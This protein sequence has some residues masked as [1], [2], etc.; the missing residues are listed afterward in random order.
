MTVENKYEIKVNIKSNDAFRIVP[1]VVANDQVVFE[2]VVWDGPS[3]FT[4]STDYTYRLT[5]KKKSGT[6]VIRDGVLSGEMIVFKLGT[7]EMTE[8]GKVEGTVQIY[9]ANDNRISSSKFDYLVKEDPSL[10]GSL[11]ADNT[12]LIIANES[13]LTESVQKSD[14]AIA[15]SSTAL[16][17][18]TAAETTA[19]DVRSE[20][21]LVVAEA[22]SSNPEVV[23]AR[24]TFVNLK[25]RLDSTDELLAEKANQTD[26]RLKTVKLGQTDMTEEFIQQMAGTTPVNAI[27]ADNSITSVK[28][29]DNSVTHLKADFL[30]YQLETFVPVN[31]YDKNA[32]SVQGEYCNP[33]TGAFQTTQYTTSYYHTDY[34]PVRP[35]VRYLSKADLGVAFYDINKVYVGGATNGTNM[36]LNGKTGYAY[37]APANAAFAIKNTNVANKDTDYLYMGEEDLANPTQYKLDMPKI[38]LNSYFLLKGKK[39]AHFGDSITEFGTYPEQVAQM[40]GATTYDCSFGGATMSFHP[41]ANYNALSMT[42][43]ADA[44]ATGDWTIQD[45]AIA[46]LKA[47]GDDN[48]TNYN[49]LKSI[50][51]ATMDAITINYGT[52]DFGNGVAIGDVNTVNLQTFAYAVRYVI[53]KI[54]TAHPHLKIYFVTPIYRYSWGM[55]NTDS[56]SKPRSDG[57][58]YLYNYTDKILEV[59]KK[60]H[61]PALDLYN[62]SGINLLTKDYYL[63]DGTHCTPKGY[64]LIA[65][66][67]SK[68]LLSN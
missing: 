31:I 18:A 8:P 51:W 60:Y 64:T 37:T 39:I 52:N 35:N 5:S 61:V 43:L 11:P 24:D 3:K 4:L 21:D 56:D 54:L 20:F 41:D 13:L 12:S 46:N 6:A 27:P 25:A 45:T 26:V 22:G 29:A 10:K 58:L 62:R 66:K 36:T 53:E 59:A 68:F 55:T 67:I 63:S 50:S 16:T 7:S 1:E 40:T 49:T 33:T 47:T 44:I 32:L 2:V 15:D 28:L 17:K 9:D 57:G 23:Q 34:L 19:N 65:D 30:D 38:N 14:A 42:K 48:T